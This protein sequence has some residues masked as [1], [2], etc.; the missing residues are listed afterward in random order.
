MI[1]KVINKVVVEKKEVPEDVK[2]AVKKAI[3][4]DKK[5]PG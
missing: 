3:V 2:S 1:K 5:L 4:E